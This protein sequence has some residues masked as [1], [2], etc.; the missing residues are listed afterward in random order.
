MQSIAL[1]GRFIARAFVTGIHSE[2]QLKQ[3]PIEPYHLV[4]GSYGFSKSLSKP[5]AF[6]K[7]TFGDD[8]FFI[9]KDKSADVIGTYHK[10]DI[11][12]ES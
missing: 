4:T 1:C 8:A 6:N 12:S 7:W 9:A 5:Q 2:F 3:R 11:L 10:T